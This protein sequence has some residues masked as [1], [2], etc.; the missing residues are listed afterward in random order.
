MDLACRACSDNMG[1]YNV[2]PL[3]RLV[4]QFEKLP[5]IGI[6]T[7]Q[8]LAYYVLNMSQN[9]ASDFAKAITDAHDKIKY[10]TVCCNFTDKEKCSIC[11]DPKR[12]KEV[13]CVVEESRDAMAIENTREFN[14]TYHV[15]HGATLLLRA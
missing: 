9:E 6:K 2:A 5:G 1:S 8:R 12:D 4:E 14:G 13:I 3:D 15:L 10:C 11:S 7:A